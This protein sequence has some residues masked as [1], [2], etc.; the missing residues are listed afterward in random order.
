MFH[1]DLALSGYSPSTAPNIYIG[2]IDG[3]LYALNAYTGSQIWT[4]S[5]E[6]LIFSSPAVADGKV[7]FLS[8]YPDGNMVKC[9][10]VPIILTIIAL[11]GV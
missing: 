10:A 9:I 7:Y 1:H 2:A 3:N 6:G 11:E 8:D 5:T 4:Y